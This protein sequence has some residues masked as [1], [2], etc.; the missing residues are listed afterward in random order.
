[1]VRKIACFL[2]SLTIVLGT[3]VSSLVST[4]IA[5]ENLYQPALGNGAL[6]PEGVSAKIKF[7]APFGGATKQES[8]PYL[9]LSLNATRAFDG[10]FGTLDRRHITRALADFRLTSDGLTTAKLGG[11]NMLNA[12]NSSGDIG[13]VGNTTFLWVLLAVAVGVGLYLVLDGS[14]SNDSD[15]PSPSQS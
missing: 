1:M 10:Q 4:A 6:A 14:D 12:G 11:I 13:N 2:L 15:S 5:A 8:E 9:G 7:A 3:S